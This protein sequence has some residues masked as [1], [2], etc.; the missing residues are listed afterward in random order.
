G[1]S[2]EIIIK[3][4]ILLDDND[5]PIIDNIN[6]FHP[7]GFVPNFKFMEE[8]IENI[9]NKSSIG[10][11]LKT[12]NSNNKV[13]LKTEDWREFYLHKIFNIT[14]GNG[15]DANKT[16][17]FDPKYN[18]VSRDSNGNGVVGVVDEIDGQLPFPAG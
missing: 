17:D 18:Y 9:V 4:P 16:T 2:K 3:L 14:M 12:N 10:S 5:N 15:I 7:N 8:Y 1:D 11:S 6:K 13:E